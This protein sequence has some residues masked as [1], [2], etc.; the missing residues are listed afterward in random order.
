MAQIDTFSRQTEKPLF[1]KFLI[2][3][4]LT[5]VFLA[6]GSSIG[7]VVFTS[8]TGIPID[9][10]PEFQSNPTQNPNAWYGM[11]VLQ[12][13]ATPLPFIGAALFYWKY[14]EKSNIQSLQIKGFASD[15]LLAVILLV[16]GFM[17]FDSLFIEWNKN[18]HL[19]EALHGI[20]TWMKK[21]EEAAKELTLF[22]TKFNSLSQFIVAILVVAVAAAISEELL[23]RGVLQNIILKKWN[24]PHLA[25]WIAAFAFSFIHFQFYGFVP[26]MLLGAIFG[27]LYIWSNNLGVAMFAHFVNNGFTLL[28][29]YLHQIGIVETDIVET[30]SVPWSGILISF[31]LSLFLL[32][33]FYLRRNT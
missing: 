3:L 1:A 10:F 14:V 29:A 8:M 6:I 24:N 21:S 28:M 30:E 13:L 4:G 19:P 32:R 7:L 20:E 26:R 33:W 16:I 15:A 9:K 12:M 18:I 5:L 22:L 23:F 27:Y 31:V 11:M 25:V 2:L 17:P